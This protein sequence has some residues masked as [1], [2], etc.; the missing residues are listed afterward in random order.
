MERS[1]R[2]AG[3]AA[4]VLLAACGGGGDGRPPNVL[5]YVVDTLRAAALAAY[6]N[7]VVDT[8][9]ADALAAEGALFERAYA[10]SSWTRASLATV[11][12]GLHPR[13]HG[14]RGRSG[15]LAAAL[16]T[17]PE[18][19]ADAGYATGG[20]IANPNV[21][22]AF[23]FDQGWDAYVELY[24]R[25]D[26]GRVT[27]RE[28]AVR[29]DV[30]TDRAIAWLDAAPEPFFLFVLPIDPHWPYEPP[31]GF[32]RYGGAY[33]G[34]LRDDLKGALAMKLTPADRARVRSLYD[35]EVAA[36]DAAFGR[37]MR[38]LRDRGLDGRTLVVFTSDHGEEFWEH[39]RTFHGKALFE[40]SI[41]VPLI[42]RDPGR[43][44][45]GLRVETP[46][47]LVDLAP[48]LLSL[49]GLPVPDDL[50]GRPLPTGE[51]RE[52]RAVHAGLAL[53]EH[54]GEAL[55]APP[56]KLLLDPTTGRR[57][58]FHLER[59]PRESHDLSEE[60]PDRA[61]AL[62]RR[63]TARIVKAEARRTHLVGDA[64]AIVP[65]DA[66]PEATRE[67]LKALGYVDEGGA[68]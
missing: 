62:F 17:L 68:P 10:P 55:L 41:R 25:R 58:L 56:W 40:E 19:F 3:L 23:G 16:E 11:L 43:I 51:T 31:A 38:H 53:D 47:G 60:A 32:D 1:P 30:V 12:T 26:V 4:A 20:I 28:L 48:T 44:R 29:S 14:V 49:A 24:A 13:S 50:D 52:G 42:V 54:H 64:H 21:G 59:D 63:M 22:S 37:L 18:R 39:G 65:D 5:L 46:V 8:P 34:P 61:D 6:G 33:D 7:P 67:A 9:A 27:S 36:N 15:L 2:F 45:A 66:V 35:G 57:W